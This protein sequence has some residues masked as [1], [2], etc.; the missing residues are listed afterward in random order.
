M[1]KDALT[2]NNLQQVL[3]DFTKDVAETYRSLLLRDGKN[4]T[5]ELI[6]SIKPMTPELVNGTFECSLSLAP[7]W[8]YVENGRRPGKFPPIENILE[9]IK[10]KPQLVRPNRLDR[11]ELAPKQL[12]FLVARKIA[13]KGI[14]PG[15]QLEEAMDIVYARWKDRIDAAITADIETIL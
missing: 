1:E 15:N 4:A 2:F 14:Q 6:S 5:G 10:A 11:K 3:D 8:K 13:T 7:H 9:W 12:A